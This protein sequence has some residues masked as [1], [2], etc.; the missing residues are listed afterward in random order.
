METYTLLYAKYISSG[1]LLYDTGEL[2]QGSMVTS[3]GGMW[4]EVKSMS[5]SDG[6]YTCS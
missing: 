4:W 3:R 6:M 2:N 1:N 5:K